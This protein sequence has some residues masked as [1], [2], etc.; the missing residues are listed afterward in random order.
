M[1]GIGSMIKSIVVL[2]IFVMIGVA[3]YYVTGLRADLAVSEINN[4]KMLEAVELQQAAI[5]QMRADQEAIRAT[6]EELA[7]TVKSAN[8]DMSALRDRFSAN[9]DGSARDIGALA[10]AKPESIQRAINRGTANALRCIEIASGA[11]LTEQERRAKTSSEINKEC[12]SIANPNYKSS[13][14]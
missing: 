2:V 9:A 4:K 10:S 5:Q 12:P 6:N 1:I 11:S 7:N 3:V 8:R 14:Q 13:T